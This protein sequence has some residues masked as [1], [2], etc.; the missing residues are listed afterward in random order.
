M[1]EVALKGDELRKIL[2][3]AKKRDLAFAYAPGKTREDDIFSIH[4]KRAPEIVSRAVR[5]ESEGTKYA[6]GMASVAGKVLSLT[7]ERE[8]PG[9]S[10]KLKRF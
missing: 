1:S 6:F 10:K 3:V 2:K 9:M 8:L 4:R 7:C 5:K